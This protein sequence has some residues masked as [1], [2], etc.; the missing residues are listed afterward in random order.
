MN[1][2]IEKNSTLLN[3]TLLYIYF[4]D[5]RMIFMSLQTMSQKK[6]CHYNSQPQYRLGIPINLLTKES[7]I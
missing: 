6:I 2:A 4:S 7:W 5:F 3:L 1:T